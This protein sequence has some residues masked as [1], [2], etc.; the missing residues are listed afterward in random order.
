M[1]VGLQDPGSLCEGRT[2]LQLMHGIGP[3]LRMLCFVIILV[4]HKAVCVAAVIVESP[5]DT[6][7]NYIFEERPSWAEEEAQEKAGVSQA[8]H[9]LKC[10]R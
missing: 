1:Q 8:L 10:I 7:H 6:Y 2:V 4:R 3:P 9:L 5:V